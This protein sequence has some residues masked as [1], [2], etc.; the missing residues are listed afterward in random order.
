MQQPLRASFAYRAGLGEER[1]ILARA[2]DDPLLRIA[3]LDLAT[4][5]PEM[6]KR[7]VDAALRAIKGEKIDPKVEF[8]PGVPYTPADFGSR[9]KEI[10]GCS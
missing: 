3:D 5:L 4:P 8:L 2:A 6:A 7:A 10:W 9:S 1:R